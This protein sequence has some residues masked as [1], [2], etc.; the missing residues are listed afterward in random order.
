MLRLVVPEVCCCGVAVR[1][2]AFD[3]HV[4]GLKERVDDF[5]G[6]VRRDVMGAICVMRVQMCA[7][8]SSYKEASCLKILVLTQTQQEGTLL[9][10]GQVTEWMMIC[11]IP[12]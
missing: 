12:R 11:A 2:D 1:N 9:T 10:D 7:K 6:N 8:W 4:V 5:P 3:A